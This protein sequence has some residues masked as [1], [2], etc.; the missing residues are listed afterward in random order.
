[1]KEGWG[2]FGIGITYEFSVRRKDVFVR[3]K[4]ED[5][6]NGQRLRFPKINISRSK[7]LEMSSGIQENRYESLLEVYWRSGRH[8]KIEEDGRQ[9][10]KEGEVLL[11]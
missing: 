9:F 3:R 7:H 4:D 8:E 1:M 10:G 6:G 5:L 2:D 11:K